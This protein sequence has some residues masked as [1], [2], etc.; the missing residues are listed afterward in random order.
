M[1]TETRTTNSF[2]KGTPTMLSPDRP[3]QSGKKQPNPHLLRLL[4]FSM[5]VFC[6]LI[7]LFGLLLLVLPMLRVQNVEI[8]G[9]EYYSYEDIKTIADI[10]EGDEI[11]AVDLH[12]VLNR[13]LEECPNVK[14]VSVS[15]S[16]PFTVVID[17]TEKNDVMY[18]AFN[19]KYISFDSGFRILEMVEGGETGKSLFS[20]FLYVTLPKIN[21]ASVGK[22]IRFQDTSADLSYIKN[23][24][25]AMRQSGVI[26]QVTK[27]DFSERFSLS[28]VLGGRCRVELGKADNLTSK[29][30]A[31]EMLLEQ[32]GGVE[33]AFAVIDVKDP[34]KATYRVIEEAEL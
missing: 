15:I 7:L 22:T 16:F 21:S 30:N 4:R 19:G 18:T 34:Q 26:E 24:L 29:F 20:P 31:V 33:A 9:I 3:P 1:N 11:L 28:Y 2:A 27:I 8:N 14:T 6:G 5:L 17:I 13:I 32:K 25:D 12:G 23:L 10:D